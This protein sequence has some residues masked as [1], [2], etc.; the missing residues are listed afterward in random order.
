MILPYIYVTT[1]IYFI[2][3]IL[4]YNRFIQRN[5]ISRRFCYRARNI[6]SLIN[7][8]ACADSISLLL[9][10]STMATDQNIKI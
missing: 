9:S 4:K 8:L 3:K 7:F 5:I 1:E 2:T 6:I 10:K